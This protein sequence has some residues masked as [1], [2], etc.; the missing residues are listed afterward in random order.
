MTRLRSHGSTDFKRANIVSMNRECPGFIKQISYQK[1]GEEK[2]YCLA[3]TIPKRLPLKYF[4][5]IQGKKERLHKS[6]FPL[7]CKLSPCSVLALVTIPE[8]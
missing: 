6:S 8:V 2:L 5:I 3:Q 1:E 4:R 7:K